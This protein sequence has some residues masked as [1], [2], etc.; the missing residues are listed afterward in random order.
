MGTDPENKNVVL[1]EFTGLN[2]PACPS[3][4]TTA[5]GIYNAHPDDTLIKQFMEDARTSSW[6]PEAKALVRQLA[7]TSTEV[8]HLSAKLRR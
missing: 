7:A 8:S 5:Q 2:C 3:G 4:H 1:E 6:G